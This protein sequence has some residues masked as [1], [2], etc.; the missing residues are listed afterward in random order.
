MKTIGIGM[1]GAGW[2]GATLMQRFHAHPHAEVVALHQRNPDRAAE[3][4]SLIG[5]SPEHFEPD[6]AAL[7]DR[8]DVDAVCICSPN[9]LH[10]PQAIA[11]LEAGKHVFC[12]KPCATEHADYLRQIELARAHPELI[13]FVDYILHFDTLE[14]RIRDMIEAG[15]LGIVTQIQVNYRHPINIAGDK[16]W[17]LSRETMGDAIG[18]GIIHSLSVMRWLMEPQTEPEWVFAHA[19]PGRVRGFEPDPVWSIQVGFDN[20]ASGFCFGNIDNG[21]GYDALHNLHGTA[22]GLVFD[23]QQDRPQKVRYWSE[24]STDGRWVW[25]LDP[26]RCL[27]ERQTPW[28]DDTTTPDSGNVIEHQTDACVDHFISCIRSAESSFLS[29]ENSAPTAAIGWAALESARTGQRVFLNPG[30]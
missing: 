7:L 28:P 14:A 18:M 9:A 29:F 5:L 30:E 22:G 16:L 19:Q 21:I 4:L 11:A 27:R 2:M 17:K 24:I 13:T 20:G 8:P 3:A 12:E 25:P 1:I 6:F 10:G 23:S 15:E 26:D